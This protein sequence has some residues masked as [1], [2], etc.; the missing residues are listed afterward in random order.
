MF[1]GNGPFC[2]PPATFVSLQ[3]TIPMGISFEFGRFGPTAAVVE[4]R[5]SK[6]S[7]TRCP[8]EDDDDDDDDDDDVFA[9]LQF[10][11]EFHV[12]SVRGFDFAT[13]SRAGADHLGSLGPC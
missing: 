3:V 9:H 2:W 12:F 6:M 5:Q 10:Y 7:M 11:F 1:A 8:S 13:V 4:Y